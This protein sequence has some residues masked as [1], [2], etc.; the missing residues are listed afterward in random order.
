MN[1]DLLKKIYSSMICSV[2]SFALICFG[3]KIQKQ[4]IDRLDK[5]VRKAEGDLGSKPGRPRHSVPKTYDKQKVKNHKR[6]HA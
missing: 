5:I 6:F 2:L 3:V 4:D 1:P